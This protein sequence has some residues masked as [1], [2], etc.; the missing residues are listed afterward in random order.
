MKTHRV[1][2]NWTWYGE[3][4]AEGKRAA[5]RVRDNNEIP[6]RKNRFTFG[7]RNRRV[8]R[9]RP[10]AATRKQNRTRRLRTGP[11]VTRSVCFFVRVR[12]TDE[13]FGRFRLIGI[14]NGIPENVPKPAEIIPYGSF[15]ATRT[16]RT[17]P[18]IVF[19]LRSITR[20]EP[21]RVVR[22][23]FFLIKK[24]HAC[25]SKRARVTHNTRLR[26]HR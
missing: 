5:E 10:S 13:F 26:S 19:S 2:V 1:N 24:K 4:G 7:I 12:I 3:G 15:N 9:G 22:F 16:F 20:N 17:T 21:S 25:H 6:A 23:S 18:G 8:P 11:R 14:T